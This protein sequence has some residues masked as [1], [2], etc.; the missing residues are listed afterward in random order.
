MLLV[1]GFFHE[2]KKWHTHTWN[3][4]TE[5]PSMTKL[6]NHLFTNCRYNPNLHPMLTVS[7]FFQDFQALVYVVHTREGGQ[8]GFIFHVDAW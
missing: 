4:H 3:S 8:K 6:H 2:N 1:F 5:Y 7:N